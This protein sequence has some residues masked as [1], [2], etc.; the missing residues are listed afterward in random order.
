MSRR[1]SLRTHLTWVVLLA[2]LPAMAIQYATN[3]ERRHE[4]KARAQELLMQ[5]VDTLASQQEQVAASAQQILTTL[6]FLPQLHSGD[7]PALNRILKSLQ[8]EDRRFANLVALDPEGRVLASSLP[9]SNQV[10]T[11]RLYFKEA[12]RTRRFTVGEYVIGRISGA[13]TLHFALPVLDE[14]RRVTAVLVAAYSTDHYQ[15]LFNT[16]ALPA[17]TSLTVADHAGTVLFHQ[18][19]LIPKYGSLVGTKLH[20]QQLLGS[21]SRGCYWAPRR[22]GERTLYAFRQIRTNGA[23]KPYLYLQVGRPEYQVFGKASGPTSG[24]CSCC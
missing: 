9:P 14:H 16:S 20:S 19:Q 17:E 22:D 24:T 8:Q 11:D 1:W 18:S 4:A 5:L 2:L 12:L 6:S 3:L 13:R 15:E 10:A 21:S 7:G 23:A